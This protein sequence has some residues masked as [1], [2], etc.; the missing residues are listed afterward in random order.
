VFYGWL[1]YLIA[2]DNGEVIWGIVFVIAIAIFTGSETATAIAAV[3][4]TAALIGFWRL[5]RVPRKATPVEAG[6]ARGI[7]LAALFCTLLGAAFYAL[8]MF[9]YGIGVGFYALIAYVAI[10]VSR[11]RREV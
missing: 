8:G 1:R 11:P 5:N 4:T 2:T 9:N 3:A 7:Y 6:G 10:A